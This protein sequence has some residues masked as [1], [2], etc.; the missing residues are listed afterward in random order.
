[1]DAVHYMPEG[2]QEIIDLMTEKEIRLRTPLEE[3][4]LLL[5]E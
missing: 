5:Q 1:M 2:V 3:I 4:Q